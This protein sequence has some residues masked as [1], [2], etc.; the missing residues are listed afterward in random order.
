MNPLVTTDVRKAAE[1]AFRRGGSSAQVL[2]EVEALK[3]AKERTS[4][5]LELR[6]Q[7]KTTPRD[8]RPS[9]RTFKAARD[10][11]REVLTE[12]QAQL[13]QITDPKSAAPDAAAAQATGKRAV[14]FQS[15][16]TSFVPGVSFQMKPPVLDPREIVPPELQEKFRQEYR[17]Q[18]RAAAAERAAAA[19]QLQARA[20]QQVG[21]GGGLSRSGSMGGGGEPRSLMAHDRPTTQ[22]APSAHLMT[23][24][25]RR[26]AMMPARLMT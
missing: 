20:R 15:N 11:L 1:R 5:L 26:Q 23:V 25:V 7:I 9:R 13:T 18:Q 14:Q 3:K 2:A 24:Q 10:E 17:E 22:L 4:Q 6:D 19:D 21:D 8:Q 12:T 16:A